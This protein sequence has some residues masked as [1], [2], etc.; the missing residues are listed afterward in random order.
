VADDDRERW[1][2]RHRAAGAAGAPSGPVPPDLLRGR[3]DLLPAGGRALDVACGRGGVAVWLAARGFVV[4]AVDVSEVALAAGAATAERHG[5][6]ERV[7]WWAHDLDAGLPA[8]CVGPY[9]AV[10][11]QRFRDPA[12]YPALSALL[13]P[14]GLLVLTV[15]SEVDEEPG[16]FRAPRGELRAAFGGLTV[17]DHRERDGEAVLLARR[18]C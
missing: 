18:P 1:D 14:G 7:R 11:C 10:V 9:E 5:V 13:A 16:R 8:G 4:D 12:L 6:G 15:L 17:L 2:A 3:E